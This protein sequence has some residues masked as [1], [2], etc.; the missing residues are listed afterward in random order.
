MTEKPAALT[1]GVYLILISLLQPRHGYAIMQNVEIL[2]TGRVNLGA[3]TL[4]GAINSLLEKR[5]ICAIGH[6][7][8]SRKKE[9]VITDVGKQ[10]LQMEIMRLGELLNIGFDAI[11][12]ITKPQGGTE[13]E[14]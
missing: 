14:N 13:H 10:I 2:T 5:W 3:G 9:Y 4:Y 7:A 6:S 12:V 1:E 8:D 11:G